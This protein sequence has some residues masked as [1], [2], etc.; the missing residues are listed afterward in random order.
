MSQKGEYH[1]QAQKKEHMILDRKRVELERQACLSPSTN[2]ILQCSS[3]AKTFKSK[4]GETFAI[5]RLDLTLRPGEILGIIGPNGAGKTTLFN[6]IGSFYR[7]SQG[8]IYLKG[9]SIEEE[10]KL[11]N[12]ANMKSFFDEVG[13]CL[14][15]DVFWEDLTIEK[16]LEVVCDMKGVAVGDED[17]RKDI[18]DTWLEALSLT[19]FRKYKA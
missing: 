15:E 5:K 8:E 1:E 11:K 12:Q 7:R 18:I 14:Q 17:L 19:N 10:Q 2:L 4:I 13:L 9:Q 16:H 3:L 6:L